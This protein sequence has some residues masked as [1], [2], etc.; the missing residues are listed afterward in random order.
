MNRRTQLIA[1]WCGPLCAVLFIIGGVLL[2]RFIPP[3]VR[4]HYSAAHTAAIFAKHAARI[5]LGAFIACISMSLVGPWGCTIA[6]QIRR[7]EGEFPILTYISISCVAI[8]TTIV[9]LMCCCWGVAAFR[10]EHTSPQITQ[11]ANDLAYF[12]F[13]FTWPPFFVWAVAVAL[14]IFTDQNEVAVFPR[15]LA[16]LSLWT[17]LLFIPAGLMVFFKHGAFSWAGLMTLYVPVAIF[18]VWL[19]GLTYCTLRNINAGHHYVRV[20]AKS[21]SGSPA[22]TP[23]AGVPASA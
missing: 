6:A 22:A 5:R 12:I 9:V 11:F 19:S 15:W 20:R 1:T 10:P 8:G 4:P 17:A 23:T 16:Y 3:Y 13:L 7:T 18:F 2:G 14:A 21:S